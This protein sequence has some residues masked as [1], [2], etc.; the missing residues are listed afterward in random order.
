VLTEAGRTQMVE[1]FGRPALRW[2]EARPYLA[3]VAL[4]E[5]PRDPEIRRQLA[6]ADGLT[7]SV[8]DHEFALNL[9]HP[10]LT[11]VIDHLAHR[12][13]TGRPGKLTLEAARAAALEQ[14][15]GGK[16]RGGSERLARALAAKTAGAGSFDAGSL[17]TGLTRRWLETDD[18]ADRDLLAFA[19]RVSTAARAV[20]A[21]GRWGE[22]N[23][24]ISAVWQQ[25]A[26]DPL[27]ASMGPVRFK[28]RLCEANR[29]GMLVLHRAD[30]VS[31]MDRRAVAE[32]EARYLN[33]TFHFIEVQR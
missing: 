2:R 33:A 24:F 5:D 26:E 12:Q 3:A 8:L 29:A 25:L 21:H 31:A 1:I 4:G 17:V 7:A 30:L 10:T 14:A 6:S 16:T 28:D 22:A 15:L 18:A 11:L 19:E 27:F 13:L 20:G 9:D 23:V 32:S